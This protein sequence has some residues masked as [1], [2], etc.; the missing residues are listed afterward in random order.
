MKVKIGIV[1]FGEFSVSHLDIFLRHPQVELVVGAELDEGRRNAIS[2][3]FGIKMYESFDQ[4]LEVDKDNLEG[5]LKKVSGLDFETSD[6]DR[7]S[8]LYDIHRERY[9]VYWTL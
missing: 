8:P 4:M 9:V 6:G 3:E 7:L 1:G 2:D 5:S